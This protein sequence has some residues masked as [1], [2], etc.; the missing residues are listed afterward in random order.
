MSQLEYQAQYLDAPLQ[1]FGFSERVL[2][3]L[4]EAQVSARQCARIVVALD[5]HPNEWVHMFGEVG[6]TMGEANILRD[7]ILEDVSGEWRNMM[8][9]IDT[10]RDDVV[11]TVLDDRGEERT[12]LA[13]EA[14]LLNLNLPED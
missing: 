3:Y 10:I 5:F 6:L 13:W 1:S 4:E 9:A 11:V 14:E 8:N 2:N 7:L 12:M